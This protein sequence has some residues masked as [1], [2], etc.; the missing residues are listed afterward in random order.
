MDFRSG[1][2]APP[3]AGRP[4]PSPRQPHQRNDVLRTVPQSQRRTA[5]NAVRR[6]RPN[7][8]SAA[9][10]CQTSQFAA[11]DATAPLS[12]RCRTVLYGRHRAAVELPQAAVAD[13]KAASDC[14]QRFS[15]R[16]DRSVGRS[17]K[18]LPAADKPRGRQANDRPTSHQPARPPAGSPAHLPTG[19]PAGAPAHYTGRPACPHR[20]KLI[21]SAGGLCDR[22]STARL[23]PAACLRERATRGSTNGGAMTCLVCR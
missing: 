23:A 2:A 12:S 18:R 13:S 5:R 7:G 10:I 1:S 19:R 14:C 4:T 22:L 16:D 17:S 15:T 8:R 3:A 6:M 9:G 11:G 21:Y 20:R